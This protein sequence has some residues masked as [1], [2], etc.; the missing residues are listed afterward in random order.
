MTT[1]KMSPD[2][3]FTDLEY[4]CALAHKNGREYCCGHHLDDS[5]PLMV[6][7]GVKRPVSASVSMRSLNQAEDR[8]NAWQNSG[9]Y[10]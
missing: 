3:V 4:A 5:H 6:Q 1:D 2:Y 10:V 7:M 8:H 9:Y